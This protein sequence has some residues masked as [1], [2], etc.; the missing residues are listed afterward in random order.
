MWQKKIEDIYV[1]LESMLAD[2]KLTAKL[3]EKQ[4]EIFFTIKDKLNLLLHSGSEDSTV[5]ENWIK[6]S[7]RPLLD[8]VGY[9]ESVN[10]AGM[11]LSRKSNSQEPLMYSE[12][13]ALIKRYNCLCNAWI[14]V[15]MSDEK[16]AEIMRRIVLT[17]KSS[18][19][20]PDLTIDWV[21]NQL[22]ADEKGYKEEIYAQLFFL[23][24]LEKIRDSLRLLAVE[25]IREVGLDACRNQLDIYGI[26]INT[27][28][29]SEYDAKTKL[30]GEIID[31]GDFLSPDSADRMESGKTEVEDEYSV[32]EGVYKEISVVFK[33]DITDEHFSG[34]TNKFEKDKTDSAGTAKY[35]VKLDTWASA[36]D[37]AGCSA[38]GRYE[39]FQ[40]EPQ[41]KV[42]RSCGCW[43]WSCSRTKT[44]PEL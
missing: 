20:M 5:K 6:F 11:H 33:D 40:P 30:P 12:F 44:K 8:T 31:S 28:A 26:V 41:S 14:V 21:D 16:I 32:R 38:K 17:L 35:E 10:M 27:E 25:Y 4:Q 3:N 37:S 23:N 1:D 7:L 2:G 42:R 36:R 29:E 15:P 43:P 34:K 18:R 22:T 13:Y 39:F 9:C 24:K 19:R